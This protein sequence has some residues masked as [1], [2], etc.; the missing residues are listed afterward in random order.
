MNVPAPVHS[1]EAQYDHSHVSDVS[2]S[3]TVGLP[4][5]APTI[6]LLGASRGNPLGAPARFQCLHYQLDFIQTFMIIWHDFDFSSAQHL[7]V[8]NTL[9]YDQTPAY[10]M[11]S[12]QPQLDSV[13]PFCQVLVG[14]NSYRGTNSFD[15]QILI[16]GQKICVQSGANTLLV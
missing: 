12:H 6:Q 5:S 2:V 8:S 13:N 4:W 10:L 15:S 1:W 3:P 11:T 7:L 16:P 14:A 9:V